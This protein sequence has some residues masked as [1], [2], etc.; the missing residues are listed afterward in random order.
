MWVQI[1]SRIP[2]KIMP[3]KKKDFLKKK[4]L[5]LALVLP[6]KLQTILVQVIKGKLTVFKLLFIMYKM[7][8]LFLS[9]SFDIKPVMEEWLV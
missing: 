7:T 3:Y 2:A 5:V 4:F 9:H 8:Y 1:V 6:L